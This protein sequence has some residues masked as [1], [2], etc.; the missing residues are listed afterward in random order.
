[1]HKTVSTFIILLAVALAGC[2]SPGTDRPSSDS[3]T[4]AG[5][6]FD[7]LG[8]EASTAA[9]VDRSEEDSTENG[10]ND[11]KEEELYNT[12]TDCLDYEEF[13]VDGSD[14]IFISVKKNSIEPIPFLRSIGYLYEK[15]LRYKDDISHITFVYKSDEAEGQF[16]FFRE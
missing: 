11:R 12:V 4:A 10:A 15:I 7:S 3:T 2:G 14:L 6:A 9:S 16:S 8:Q 5:S 1:M 13:I